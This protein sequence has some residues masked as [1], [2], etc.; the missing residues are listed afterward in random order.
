MD[1]SSHGPLRCCA[2]L[3]RT[4]SS[5]SLHGMISKPSLVSGHN[6]VSSKQTVSAG[7]EVTALAWLS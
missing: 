5:L 4:A 3:P 1:Y 6:N 2:F 7:I